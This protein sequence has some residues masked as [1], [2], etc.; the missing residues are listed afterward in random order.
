VAAMLC[1]VAGLS[2]DD[3]PGQV[4]LALTVDEEIGG[5]GDGLERLV[6]ELGRLDAAV[7]GE[8]TSLDI[9]VAQKGLLI[10]EVESAGVARHAAHAHRLPGTNAVSEAARAITALDGWHPDAASEMLGPATCQIT[11][12]RGG[13]GLN[14]IPGHCRFTLDVR[15]VPGL[16]TEELVQA[17]QAR[18]GGEAAVTVLE[19][20]LKPFETPVDA[21]IVRAA[22]QVRPDARVV[23]SATLSDA[24]WTRQWPTIKV[25]PGQTERSH[26]VDEFITVGELEAGVAFYAELIAAFL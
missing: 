23:G 20:K 17:V 26:T 6:G 21:A 22:R 13:T 1:A 3:L 9:C 24:C 11:T 12:V 16:E 19:D 25:G 4:V 10:L 15:T 18:V 2:A 5:G 14:K 7:I 8:P